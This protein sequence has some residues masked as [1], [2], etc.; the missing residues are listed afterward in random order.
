MIGLLQRLIPDTPIP[1]IRESLRTAT[2]IGIMI[3]LTGILSGLLAPQG[4]APILV[5]SMGASAMIMLTLP[6]S[7][8]AQPWPDGRISGFSQAHSAG[9][10]TGGC[11]YPY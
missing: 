11:A 10:V 4:L 2:A 9:G 1:P 7:P 8:L 6:A 3:L 5:A